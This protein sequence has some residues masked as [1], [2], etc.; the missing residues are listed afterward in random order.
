M[1]IVVSERSF[2]PKDE[3]ANFEQS[4][5]S[6]VGAVASFSGLVREEAGATSSLF[7]DS[8]PGFTERVIAGHAE[9]AAQRFSLLAFRIRHRTGEMKPGDAIVF[10]GAAA[11]HR[12]AALDAV[13]YLMDHLKSAAPFWKRETG[14]N[15]T[16]WIEPTSED[17][18]SR[19][20]W[21]NNRARN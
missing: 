15:G 12:R 5:P 3:L 17:L 13:D 6:S 20:A 4:L 8:Y 2:L 11:A 19:K 7:L 21:E 16:R 18:K 1:S 9:E 10:V 14:P